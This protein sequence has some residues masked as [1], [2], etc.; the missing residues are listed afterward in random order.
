M[1]Y[2][3]VAPVGLVTTIVPVGTVHVGCTVTDAV[4]VAGAPGTAL[5]TKF[6]AAEIHPVEVFL[7]VIL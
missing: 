5:T 7:V 2:S 1:L 4:G 6:K 3:K